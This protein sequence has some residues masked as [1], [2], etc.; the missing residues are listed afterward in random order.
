MEGSATAT[1]QNIIFTGNKVG[2]RRSSGNML[3]ASLFVWAQSSITFSD[4][5]FTG[6]A[7]NAAINCFHGG[8]DHYVPDGLVVSRTVPGPHEKGMC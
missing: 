3:A 1:I 6:N 8:A 2:S 4:V 7:D 5:T